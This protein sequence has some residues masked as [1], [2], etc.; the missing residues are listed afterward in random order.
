MHAIGYRRCPCSAHASAR[1]VSGFNPLAWRLHK[2][3]KLRRQSPYCAFLGFCSTLVVERLATKDICGALGNLEVCGEV[4]QR[5]P[6]LCRFTIEA[7]VMHMLLSILAVIDGPRARAVYDKMRAAYN[8]ALL[9][10]TAAIPPFEEWQGVASI[11]DNYNCRLMEF[12]ANIKYDVASSSPPPQERAFELPGEGPRDVPVHGGQQR[13][14]PS[15][16]DSREGTEGN[17]AVL[18]PPGHGAIDASRPNVG[19]MENVSLDGRRTMHTQTPESTFTTSLFREVVSGPM[20]DSDAGRIVDEQSISNR[21]T[22]LGAQAA[23]ALLLSP[24]F[25]GG[26]AMIGETEE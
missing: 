23:E 15:A 14:V 9:P 20:V 18:S 21:R 6:G 7:H 25:S 26:G 5:Y 17:S 11:C 1:Q 12:M 13:G 19:C 2:L 4:F 16:T 8:L 22:D 10:G 3:K 24:E